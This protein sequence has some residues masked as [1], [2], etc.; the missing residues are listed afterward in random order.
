M[1]RKQERDIRNTSKMLARNTLSRRRFLQTMFATGAGALAYGA[2][3]LASVVAQGGSS[4]T[5]D[6]AN[7]FGRLNPVLSTAIGELTINNAV[8]N[9]VPALLAE[10][11]TQEDDL[12]WSL[13]FRQG[14]MFH[15]GAEM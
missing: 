8:F 7:S 6:I 2:A 5:I 9:K 1:K 10:A 3:P 13:S 12:T 11:P 15:D 4:A 14:V